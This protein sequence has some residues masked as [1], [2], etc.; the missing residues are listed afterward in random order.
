MISLCCISCI[1]ATGAND[2]EKVYIEED[3]LFIKGDAF[4]IHIGNNVWL[5]TNSIETDVD[6]IYTR[7]FNI[8]KSL[9]NNQMAYEKCWKCPY[10]HNYWPVGTKCQNSECPSKYKFR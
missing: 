7:E 3:D 1:H 6:G 2:E 5:V 8:S 4:H 10:C 9:I